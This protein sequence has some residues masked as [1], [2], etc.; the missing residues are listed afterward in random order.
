MVRLPLALALA[1]AAG[2]CVQTDSIGSETLAIVGGTINRGDPAVVAILSTFDGGQNLCTGALIASDVVLTA[3][4]CLNGQAPNLREVWF[5]PDLGRGEDDPDYIDRIEAIDSVFDIG[6]NINDLEAGH[7]IGMIRLARPAPVTPIPV[8]RTATGTLV[9]ETIRLTGY[10]RT[11]GGGGGAGLK[12]ETL[13]TIRSFSE[14]FQVASNPPDL[15]A[16]GSGTEN[17]CQGDS[18]GPNLITIEGTEYVA[19]VTS[20]GDVNCNIAGAGTRVDRYLPFIDAYVANSAAACVD[21]GI[22]ESACAAPDPDCAADQ[23]GADGACGPG[24]GVQDVDCGGSGGLSGPSSAV[25]GGCAATG[26]S[27]P[28]W[29]AIAVLGVFL[30]GRRRRR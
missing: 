18:G 20:F 26:D 21:D 8:N 15:I 29:T 19:G 14:A 27:G 12:R 22:C 11:E 6:F 24:C 2:A 23:C 17:T 25:S 10:G 9:G 13:S 30:A 5:V 3:A 16:Y 1:L 4:H 28:P 7:D